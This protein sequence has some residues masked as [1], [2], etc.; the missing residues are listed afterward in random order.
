MELWKTSLSKVNEKAGQSL[1]SP[2]LYENLFPMFKESLIAEQYLAKERNT[3]IPAVQAS[4]PN[5]LQNHERK[6]IEEAMA[7]EA[8]GEFK[9]QPKPQETEEPFHEAQ[10]SPL[11]P[12]Q[13][14]PDI[15][16]IDDDDE[17]DVDIDN[18]QL[19][20]TLDTGDINL[21]VDLLSED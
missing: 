5:F 14:S 3:P 10:G 6:P 17:L 7:S 19:D 16:E 12:R 21:D 2:D 1:A 20:D 9:F 11:R 18:L 4:N 15:D 8:A 13:P